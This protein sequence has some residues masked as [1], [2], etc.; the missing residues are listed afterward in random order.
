MVPDPV[1]ITHANPDS[2]FSHKRNKTDHVLRAL[3]ERA[4]P[5]LRDVSQHHRDHYSSSLRA[6]AR[7]VAE[8]ST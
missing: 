7:M 6:C 2:L 5:R 1:A 4:D 8:P 3:A